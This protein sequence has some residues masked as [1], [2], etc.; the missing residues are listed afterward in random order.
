MDSKGWCSICGK[1]IKSNKEIALGYCNDCSYWLETK[2]KPNVFIIEGRAYRI[3]PKGEALPNIM[4]GGN[5]VVRYYMTNDF[6]AHITNDVWTIGTIPS[7]LVSM[8]PNNAYWLTRKNYERLM[9]D[10]F[11]CY[12][13]G[14]LDRYRC[15]RYE[16]KTEYGKPPF[17]YPPRNWITGSEH[18]QSF[19]NILSLKGYQLFDANDLLNTNIKEK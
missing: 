4:L 16:Y 7:Y 19:I 3:F 13:R 5:G 11:K 8:I 1:T 12:A 6:V 2:E 18:C 9:R 14:C 17:N 15:I 10:K